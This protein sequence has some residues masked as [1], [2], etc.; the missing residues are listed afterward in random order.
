MSNKKPTQAALAAALGLSP[1]RITG[2]KR[3]GMPTYSVEAARAWAARRFSVEAMV[4]G[5]EAAYRDACGPV[6]R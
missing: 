1:G 6:A 5:T 2:L 4:E 3:H